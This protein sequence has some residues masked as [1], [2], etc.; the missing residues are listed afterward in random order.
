M[1][2]CV[3]VQ[4]VLS[5]DCVCISVRFFIQNIIDDF[6][7]LN[8]VSNSTAL[9]VVHISMYTYSVCVQPRICT[10]SFSV[11]SECHVKGVCNIEK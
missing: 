8:F 1:Y 5:S 9:Q 2:V 10:L 3:H 6:T 7:I 11:I 4:C